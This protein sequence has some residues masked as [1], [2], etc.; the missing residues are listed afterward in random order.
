[1]STAPKELPSHE[2]LSQLARDDPDAYEALRREM[3][4]S[5]IDSAP[6]RLTPRLKGLQFRI[7][8]IRRLSKSGLGSTIKIYEMMWQSFLGLNG[9]W[10]EMVRVKAGQASPS[11]AGYAQISNAQILQ[12]RSR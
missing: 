12:F 7:D 1:M 2:V 4:D 5:F 10:Q 6:P 9:T 8:G 11:P 3:I